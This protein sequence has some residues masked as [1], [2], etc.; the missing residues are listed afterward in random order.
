MLSKFLDLF[1]APP[2]HPATAPNRDVAMEF[3]DNMNWYIGTDFG[4]DTPVIEAFRAWNCII[5]EERL[6]S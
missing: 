4:P 1:R 2:P 5:K 6:A 3:L